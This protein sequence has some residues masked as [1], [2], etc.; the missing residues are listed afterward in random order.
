MWEEQVMCGFGREV[1]C[2]EEVEG[3]VKEVMSR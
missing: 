1:I 2:R 3:D